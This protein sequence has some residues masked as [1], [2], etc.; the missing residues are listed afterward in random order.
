MRLWH[1]PEECTDAYLFMHKLGFTFLRKISAYC[2]R[3]EAL[4]KTSAISD[5]AYGEA[6]VMRLFAAFQAEASGVLLFLK[7]VRKISTY[8]SGGTRGAA[9]RLLF[10]A[11]LKPQVPLET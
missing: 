4:A 3:T 8:V 1:L 9:P 10:S 11:S 7:S 6:D 5:N 2:H